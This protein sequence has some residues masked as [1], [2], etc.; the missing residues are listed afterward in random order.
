MNLAEIA[1]TG[2]EQAPAEQTPVQAETHA[3]VS[4]ESG[5]ENGSVA[6]SLGLNGKMFAFQLINFA[7]VGMI[8]WFLILKPL[9]S[10]LTERQKKIEESLENAEKVEKNLRESEKKYQERIDESKVEANKIIEKAVAESDRVNIQ[11]K[12]K[13]KEEIETLVKQA[14]KNIELEKANMMVELKNA[15]ADLVVAALEKV[16]TEK[17]TD[18]NDKKMIE[19]TVKKLASKTETR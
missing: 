12:E 1:Q 17:M 8:L 4:E 15:T 5:V 7:L 14:K 11:L 9:V 13:A 3:T 16:L 2:H 6:A 18:K 19:E 10:K